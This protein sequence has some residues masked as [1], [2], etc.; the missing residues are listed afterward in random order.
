MVD[1][2]S[3]PGLSG[4]LRTMGE[5]LAQL[6]RENFGATGIS[7]PH[8]WEALRDERYAR[9]VGRDY[10]T[11][12]VTGDL[13]NS[14]ECQEPIGNMVTVIAGQGDS[15]RY[16]SAHQFGEGKMPE[17]PFFPVVGDF[18]TKLTPYAEA[19]ITE[20]ANNELERIFSR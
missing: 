7:R 10:A 11:L 5:T 13:F 19:R 18:D 4:L 9:K 8:E 16:A 14:I 6:T 2:L 1:S 20:A 12:Y 15:E 3:G 17:R